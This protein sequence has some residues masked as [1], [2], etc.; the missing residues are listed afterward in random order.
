MRVTRWRGEG[1]VGLVRE[2]EQGVSQTA[3]LSRRE[4]LDRL[5][6]SAIL[7]GLGSLVA[8]A[9]RFL[10]PAV[11]LSEPTRATSVRPDELKAEEP[12]FVAENRA[13]LLRDDAGIYALSAICSHLGCTVRWET[14]AFGCPCH[15]SRYDSYGRV[16]HGPATRALAALWVGLD[17]EGRLVVDRSRTV[18]PSARL[19]G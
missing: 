8:A 2:S 3:H 10:V 9:A 19:M 13:W 4:F 15:S 14:G 18:P 11:E 16:Q 6:L 5:G 17:K 7:L 12:V 1:Q